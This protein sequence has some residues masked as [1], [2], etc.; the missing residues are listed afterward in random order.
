MPARF[1]CGAPPPRPA[2][3]FIGSGTRQDLVEAVRWYRRAAAAGDADAESVLGTLYQNGTAGLPRSYGEAA[4]WHR[5]AALQGNAD[6][7]GALGD[8]YLAGGPILGRFHGHRAGHAL[9]NQL[10]RALFANQANWRWTPISADDEALA[11]RER[12]SLAEVLRA[13]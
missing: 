3:Y 11:A 7:Q 5:K 2:L 4:A 12:T 13:S 8:L 1:A 9:N 6:S 10:L